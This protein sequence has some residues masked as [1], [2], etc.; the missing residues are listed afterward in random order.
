MKKDHTPF[1]DCTAALENGELVLGNAVFRRRWQVRNGLLYASSFVALDTGRE[2]L[3]RPSASPSPYPQVALPDEPRTVVLTTYAE[4]ASAVGEP[5]LAARLTAT[6]EKAALVYDFFIHPAAA[7][8]RIRLTIETVR[9]TVFGS[10]LPL[11][12][13]PEAAPGTWP[14]MRQESVLPPFDGM[15]HLNLAPRHVRL[16]QVLLED[17]TDGHNELVQEREWLLHSNEAHLALKGNLFVIEDTIT[18][19]GLV[20]LKHAP[21]PHARPLKCAADLRVHAKASVSSAVK[22][23]E[24]GPRHPRWPLAFQLGFFGHGLAMDEAG[25]GYP[26]AL[27]AYSGGR[28]GR[29]RA[30]QDYQRQ[31]RPYVAGRDG[32]IVANTWG[33]RSGNSRIS[34]P[35]LLHEAE[36][37]HAMGVEVL[38]VDDGWQRGL[39]GA[40]PSNSTDLWSKFWDASDSYWDC[41]PRRLPAGLDSLATSAR[42]RGMKLGLWY[43]VDPHKAYANWRRDAEKILDL[44]SRYGVCYFKLDGVSVADR[45]SETNFRRFVD[46]VLTRSDGRIVLD[47]DITAGRRPGYFGM[48]DSGPIFVEN[49]YT[50]WHGYWPHHTLRNLWSLA[51]YVDPLRLRFEFLNNVRNAALYTDDLLAPNR[52]EAD[53]LFATVMFS[54]PL[55]WF[56]AQHV[57]PAFARSAGAAIAAWKRCRD[58]MFDGTILPIGARPDGVAWTGFASVARD[59]QSAVVLVFRELNPLHAA[60]LDIPL[61]G[62]GRFDCRLLAGDGVGQLE[63]GQ[64]H[65]VI[66]RPLRFALFKATRSGLVNQTQSV[67]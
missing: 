1:P 46:Q 6:G 24:Y 38:Q 29:I 8:V 37:G 5:G 16:T 53:C 40:P 19:D 62:G 45:A 66:E 21:L 39:D 23:D 60:E 22:A 32:L 65:T 59:G 3:A 57:T 35:F 55:A 7:G 20:F 61:L 25:E 18:G 12:P 4:R 64:L 36:A 14:T 26:F 50:D 67:P 44:H 63:N 47:H 58:D 31:I 49:R 11:V 30:L 52:Y 9:D 33:D 2:W 56:E 54:S 51:H 42:E 17:G 28:P 27:L 13:D 48:M 43:V 15:E 10:E 41:H 34:E